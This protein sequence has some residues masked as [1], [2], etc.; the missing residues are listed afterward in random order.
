VISWTGASH[1]APTRGQFH[2]EKLWALVGAQCLRPWGASRSAP[3]NQYTL[4][5]LGFLKLIPGFRGGKAMVNLIRFRFESGSFETGFTVRIF[6]SQ[7][8]VILVNLP[9]NPGLPGIYRTWESLY[10]K[11]ADRLLLA[12][13]YQAPI[14]CFQDWLKG[15]GDVQKLRETILRELTDRLPEIRLLIQSGDRLLRQLPWQGWDIF[16]E[17]YPQ[18]ELALTLTE[19]SPLPDFDDPPLCDCI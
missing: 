5:G 19:Y 15:G 9:P 8:T 13:S 17:H 18:G 11:K 2:D 12:Q 14:D 3:T 1:F 16:R 10:L 7:E 6:F 4:T